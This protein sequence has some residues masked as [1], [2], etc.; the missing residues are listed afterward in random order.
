MDSVDYFNYAIV[1]TNIKYLLFFSKINNN[2]I[3]AEIEIYDGRHKDY[4]FVSK[5]YESSMTTIMFIIK[6]DSIRKVYHTHLAR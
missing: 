3:S 6:D 2:L 1:D 5:N 4:R